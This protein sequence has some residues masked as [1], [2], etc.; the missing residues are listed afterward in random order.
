MGYRCAREALQSLVHAYYKK[1]DIEG[2]LNCVTD[3]IFWIGTESFDCANGK[4]DLRQLLEKDLE[5][6]PNPFQIKV[7]EPIIQKINDASVMFTVSG[8]QTEIPNMAFGL[9]VRATICIRNTETGWLV[10]NVHVSV[11]NTELEK[12]ILE[13]KLDET[14][15]KEQVL[16]AS[17]PGGVAIYRAKKNGRFAT[18]Y[19]SEGLA[20]M[21]GY[22]VEEFMEYL[23]EDALVNVVSEDI[24]MVEKCVR[25]ALEENV[26]ISISYRIYSKDKKKILIQ[27][28]ANIMFMEQL[29][30][31]DVAILYAVHTLVSD[32]KKKTAKEQKRYRDIFNMLGTACWEWSAEDGYYNSDKYNDYAISGEDQ[33]A[34]WEDSDYLKFIHPEDQQIIKEFM[35]KEN[36]DNSKK[37]IVIR[38][39]MKDGSFRWTEII[40]FVEHDSDEHIVRIICVMKDVDQEWIEQKKKLEFALK[41]AKE[42][43]QA[44]TD[45]LSTVSHDMR[46]PLNGILG[47][48]TLLKENVVNEKALLDLQQLEMS[49]KYLL[50]LINDTLDVSKIEN[51]KLELHPVICDG[52]AVFDNVIA[53]LNP[54]LLKKR[55]QLNMNAENLPFTIL[56]IDVGRVEQIVMNILGNAIK[57]T[58]KGGTID[59]HM[60]NLSVKDGVIL[61]EIVI[62]D[63]GIGMSQEFLPHLFEPFSQENHSRTTSYKGTG[64]GMAITKQLI[65]LMGGEIKVESTENV[66]TTFTFTLPMAI[67]TEEQ[68]AEWKMSKSEKASDYMLE[69]KRVL[70]CEDHPLNATIATRLLNKKG[71]IVEHA[72]NGKDGVDMFQKSSIDYYDLIL[73]DIRMPVMDGMEAT[74]EI[75]KLL[76]KDANE[77]PIVAMTAN[78]FEEDMKQAKDVGMNAYLSK[79]IE[80]SQFY[81]TLQNI[82][83]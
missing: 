56:Y 32:E 30:E 35:S 81:V 68:V 67:A 58:P 47:L 48:T 74:R 5:K 16:M 37:S 7:E 49:G 24:P 6:F 41:T 4:D 14:R 76:R 10:C 12:Y 29:G 52:K 27:L 15:K 78:A 51:G 60:R 25:K 82:L 40:C 83:L 75:R 26:P 36:Y 17:I 59:F 73:M 22:T 13:K 44:K 21:C 19:I 31:D 42:A 23:K 18:D 55:I 8:H 43:N 80:T 70:L 79:P 71:M 33:N 3:D 64:L 45:F 77:I 34:I 11:P 65:T 2:I 20:R 38:A 9:N 53:L 28:D 72:E 54:N 62:K 39:K 63:N 1:R 66:G 57:F 46:T 69:G 50:N 61:D